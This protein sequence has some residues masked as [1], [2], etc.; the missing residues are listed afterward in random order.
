VNI[1]QLRYF[2]AVADEQAKDATKRLQE[3]QRITVDA[4][5]GWVLPADEA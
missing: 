5:R 2:I 1:R 3:A 4:T